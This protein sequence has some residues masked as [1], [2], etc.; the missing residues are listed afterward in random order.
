MSSLSS[1]PFL[2]FVF[3]VQHPGHAA[4]PMLTV[5]GSKMGVFGQ[6]SALWSLS[7]EK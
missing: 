5:K 2:L 7:D 1:C 4:G 6:G 3:F